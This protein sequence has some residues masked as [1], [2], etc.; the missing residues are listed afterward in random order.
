MF[1]HHPV[2]LLLLLAGRSV[3]VRGAEC[4]QCAG[5]AAEEGNGNVAAE[6]CV[7]VREVQREGRA[8]HGSSALNPP[9]FESQLR[10]V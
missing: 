5:G 4:V 3:S 8:G 1:S 6:P 9:A 10:P 7:A 2:L